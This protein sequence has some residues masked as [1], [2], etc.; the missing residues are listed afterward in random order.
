[1]RLS[2]NV[3]SAA[4]RDVV[5][6]WRPSPEVIR[7]LPEMH[8]MIRGA[9]LAWSTWHEDGP[10][11]SRRGRRLAAALLVSDTAY[12]LTLAK[13]GF[14]G[15]KGAAAWAVADALTAT[16]AVAVYPDSGKD[17]GIAAALLPAVGSALEG[18]YARGPLSGAASL[19]LPTS[20]AVAMRRATGRPT[21]TADLLTWPLTACS[22][23][24]A[25]RIHEQVSRHRQVR[26]EQRRRQAGVE[27]EKF[28]G[29]VR[30]GENGGRQAIDQIIGEYGLLTEIDARSG[31]GLLDEARQVR[32][33]L[34]KISGPRP[35]EPSPALL[36]VVLRQ[37]EKARQNVELARRVF[38]GEGQ[39]AHEPHGET[40]RLLL[41]EG[42][43]ERLV[44]TLDR[45]RVAGT[46]SVIV[47]EQHERPRGWDLALDVHTQP[48]HGESR[49]FGVPLPLT[50]PTWQ[51]ELVTLG[52][53]VESLWQLSVC[54]SGH[55]QVPVRVILPAA[56]MNLLSAAYAEYVQRRRPIRH[57]ADLT[58]L[59]LPSCLYVAA[60][61][62]R[63]MRRPTYNPGGTPMHPGLH[64]LCGALYLWG[65][66][67]PGM[68]RPGKAALLGGAAAVIGTSWLAS[69][70]QPG[71]GQA[72]LAELLWSAL[73][74]VGS[75]RLGKTI[76]DMGIRVTEEQKQLSV[77]AAQ[78]AL[79]VGWDQ[80]RR[81]VRL[82][83]D[84]VGRTLEQ[85][86]DKADLLDERTAVKV[87]NMATHHR[88]AGEHLARADAH[89]PISAHPGTP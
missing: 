76:Q 50:R 1:M 7:L 22:L 73:A 79:L 63:T 21:S 13:G 67:F 37:Y 74:G 27:G 80:Q 59:L 44:T 40:G 30:Y 51:L 82:L 60:A 32:R 75:V 65:S 77:E 26:A 61:G 70:R 36:A 4:V 5:G 42:Q 71:D 24:F 16:A 11:R 19:V 28:L 62:P 86:R 87:R 89:P 18:T 48:V 29:S 88:R 68:S 58:L 47:R 6:T 23:G 45:E 41:D 14:S 43:V 49:L 35:S 34:D 12:C 84:L 33:E 39:P 57:T 25:L 2:L 66:Q 85:L 38:L 31:G 10:L 53:A 72:F 54:S 3:A 69:R 17:A 64:V 52:L 46:L 9:V 78:K 56:A 8:A 20:A 15:R 83:Y 81:R 55:A